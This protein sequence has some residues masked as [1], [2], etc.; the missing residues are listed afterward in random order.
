MAAGDWTTAIATAGAARRRLADP[1]HPALG[2]AHYQEAELHRLVGAFDDADAAYRRASR[3]GHDPT[4]G[5]ALLELARGN[6]GE[7]ATTIRRGLTE[8]RAP[9]MLAAAV[10][11]L[12]AAGDAAGAR[13]AAEALAERASNTPSDVLRAMATQATGAVRIV[14]GDADSALPVLRAAAQAWQQL[15]MPYEGARTAVLLAAA[16][17]ALGDRAAAEL[18]RENARAAF[19]ELGA[20]PDLERLAPHHP[21][22]R[23]RGLS[24]RERE[25]L[26]E[27]AAGRTNREIAA[28][29]HL[30][31][32]TVGRHVENIFTKLGVTSRAAATARAYEEGL[33]AH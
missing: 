14:D 16:L 15:R 6:T 8:T 23:D 13:A 4:P 19:S 29:L 2:L 25:I 5:L 21:P 18:E 26:A 12:L 3:H 33:L 11:I 17:D 27:L 31:Q 28:A 10:E 32:H 1:P 30:S 9:A 24:A 7:A 20:R 22:S